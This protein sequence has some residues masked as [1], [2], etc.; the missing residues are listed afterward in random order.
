MEKNLK[1]SYI[2]SHFSYQSQTCTIQLLVCRCL[3][4][5][6]HISYFLASAKFDIYDIGDIYDIIALMNMYK[7]SKSVVF[8]LQLIDLI[9]VESTF[10]R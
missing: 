5:H 2:L 7:I 10:T 3:F 1:P 6:E 4:S 9:D 8:L